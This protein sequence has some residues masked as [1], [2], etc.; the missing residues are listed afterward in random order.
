MTTG[1]SSNFHWTNCGKTKYAKHSA[2]MFQGSQSSGKLL[3]SSDIDCPDYTVKVILALAGAGEAKG[4]K[5]VGVP[6]QLSIV[7][8]GQGFQNVIGTVI[9]KPINFPP[10]FFA[11]PLGYKKITDERDLKT[12]TLDSF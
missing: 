11:S 12:F 6:L 1:I 5:C 7:D 2:L 9:V 4:I 3:V 8:S 10:S